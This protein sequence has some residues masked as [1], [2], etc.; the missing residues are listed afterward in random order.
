MRKC[1]RQPCR[2]LL[3]RACCLVGFGRMGLLRVQQSQ[4]K[5][6]DLLI[7]ASAK[8]HVKEGGRQTRLLSMGILP[9]LATVV[10]TRGPSEFYHGTEFVDVYNDWQPSVQSMKDLYMLLAI[11]FCWGCCVFGSMKV[12]SIL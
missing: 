2:R 1:C 10:V 4:R 11:V 7:S 9:V 5:G 12:G 8:K 3:T 6:S